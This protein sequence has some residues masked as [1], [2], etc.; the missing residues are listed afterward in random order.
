MALTR[1]SVSLRRRRTARLK[2]RVI[3]DKKK[4]A[5]KKGDFMDEIENLKKKLKKQAEENM[6]ID[7]SD[8][9]VHERYVKEEDIKKAEKKR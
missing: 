1:R 8:I 2:I 4:S 9:P 5:Q 6:E 7:D 3:N